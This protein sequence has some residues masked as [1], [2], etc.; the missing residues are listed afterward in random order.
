MNYM[1]I[2]QPKHYLYFPE[3]NCLIEMLSI[4]PFCPFIFPLGENILQLRL[5]CKS[6]A[7]KQKVC[8]PEYQN[9]GWLERCSI[10]TSLFYRWRMWTQR[11]EW[12]CSSS[13]SWQKI[14]EQNPILFYS[15]III[16]LYYSATQFLIIVTDYK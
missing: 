16:N 11:G 1:K 4:S 5:L 3:S 8:F 10:L 6:A 14:W 9:Q 2:N 13:E 12:T 7:S 15:L